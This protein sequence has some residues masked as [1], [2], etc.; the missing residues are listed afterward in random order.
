MTTP[1]NQ[2]RA[3]VANLADAQVT[4]GQV[5]RLIDW[6][7]KEMMLHENAI[8]TLRKSLQHTRFVID[9]LHE[10]ATEL[11]TKISNEESP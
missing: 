2:S 9:A 5:T 11:K 8:A 3:T 4:H 6:H 7:R 10:E 1:E